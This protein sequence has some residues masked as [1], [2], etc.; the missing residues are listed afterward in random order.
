MF[1][2]PFWLPH[3]VAACVLEILVVNSFVIVE[4]CLCSLIAFCI[5]WLWLCDSFCCCPH[6]FLLL[7]CS[8]GCCSWNRM[9]WILLPC[10]SEESIIVHYTKEDKA[11]LWL[12]CGSI[13]GENFQLTWNYLVK[14]ENWVSVV[15]EGEICG[16]SVP[17]G[18]KGTIMSTW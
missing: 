7:W 14:F 3:W 12:Q 6:L 8:G 11:F 1:C 9:L 17:C 13:F 2:Y 10:R 5:C 18:S 16:F 4:F 15:W